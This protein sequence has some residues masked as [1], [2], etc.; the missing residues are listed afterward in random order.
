MKKCVC[1]RCGALFQPRLTTLGM[2]K[3]CPDCACRNLLDGLDLPTPPILLDRHTKHP[4]L[5]DA[6]W[7]RELGKQDA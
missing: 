3:C 1:K 7:R 4:T 5:T 2:T 6:E